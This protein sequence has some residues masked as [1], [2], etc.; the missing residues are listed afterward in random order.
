[1]SRFARLGRPDK[2]GRVDQVESEATVD[3]IGTG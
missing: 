2:T 3:S 1:M